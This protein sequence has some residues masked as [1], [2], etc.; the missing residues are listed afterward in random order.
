MKNS[1]FLAAA[2]LGLLGLS[3]CSNENTTLTNQNTESIQILETPSLESLKKNP[4]VIWIGEVN[5][6]YGLNYSNY[7]AS[8]D[9]KKDLESIGFKGT[10]VYKILKY[11]IADM[12]A[13]DNDEHIF[14]N[15][16]IK[17]IEKVSCYKDEQLTEALS[18]LE[19]RKKLESVDTIITFD[20]HTMKELAQVVVNVVDP[21]EVKFFRLKQIIYYNTKEAI[22]K[23]IPLAI[24]PMVY[25][26]NDTNKVVGV[27]PLF[28]MKPSFI[29]AIPS[30]GAEDITWAERMYRNF[31]VKD[32]KVLKE[33]YSFEKVIDTMFSDLHK[34]ADKAIVRSVLDAD[35]TEKLTAKEIKEIGNSV[36]TIVTFDP[37]TFKETRTVVRNNFDGKSVENLRLIQDFVWNAKTNQLCIRYVGFKPIVNRYDDMGNFLNSGPMFTMKVGDNKF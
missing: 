33:D 23:T 21:R 11:Q 6:D 20:P 10:N 15:K 27:T 9:E 14:I 2:F 5:V 29:D 19:S 1:K 17:N 30:L 12:E 3:S 31:P 36:D 25:E 34:N 16:L 28:W 32:I 13:G 4:D 35:G 24:A 37:N 26:R 7:E 18:P 8:P 22:F